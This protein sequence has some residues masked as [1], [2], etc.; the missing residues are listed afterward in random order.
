MAPT[1]F[2]VQGLELVG[3]V[4]LGWLFQTR[5]MGIGGFPKLGVPFGESE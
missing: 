5:A 4:V 2:R 1:R 3:L